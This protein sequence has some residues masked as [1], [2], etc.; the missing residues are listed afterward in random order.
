[1]NEWKE[2]MLK[3]I[4]KFTW[5]NLQDA[6]IKSVNEVYEKVTKDG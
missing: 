3:D 4:K 6:L 2:I 1:M 5:N